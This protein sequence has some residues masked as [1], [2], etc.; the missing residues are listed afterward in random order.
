MVEVLDWTG[1]H[2]L[3]RC[4]AT[5][6]GSGTVAVVG[7]PG[8]APSDPLALMVFA[9]TGAPLLYISRP[10]IRFPDVYLRTSAQ[11]PRFDALRT[12]AQG[13]VAPSAVTR[14]LGPAGGPV[15]PGFRADATCR[16]ATYGA[17]TTR[18]VPYRWYVRG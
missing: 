13:G 4:T 1:D 6:G 7:S 15:P 16:V 12:V 10:R 14:I 8:I 2:P 11:G 9:R 5:P 3:L 18:T 17:G